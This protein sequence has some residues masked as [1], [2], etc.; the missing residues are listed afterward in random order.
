MRDAVAVSRDADAAGVAGTR[1][2][3]LNSGV[4]VTH[5]HAA[6]SAAGACGAGSAAAGYGLRV[7]V[8]CG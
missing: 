8:T 4:A 7:V 3:I 6:D 5:D 1:A 2:Q